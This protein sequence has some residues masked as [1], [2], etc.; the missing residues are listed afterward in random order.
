MG[1]DRF[2]DCEITYSADLRIMKGTVADCSGEWDLVMLHHSLEHME[3]QVATLSTARRLLS[4]RGYVL[5]R[6]PV[7][8]SE[9]WDRY[10]TDWA[11]LD[12]PRH[13]FLHS[14]RSLRLAAE[15]AGLQVVR[16]IY[17]SGA[18]Q[19]WASEQYRRGIP[20]LSPESFALDPQLSLFTPA[21]IEDFEA[22]ARKLNAEARGDQAAFLLS[23]PRVPAE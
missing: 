1:V 3:D 16:V 4:P 6:I 17:D 20:L 14:E 12:A 22:K 11:Q 9:A 21:Q 5:V 15:L 13:F 23:L 8:S 2:I 10:G 19:F 7:V 18:F